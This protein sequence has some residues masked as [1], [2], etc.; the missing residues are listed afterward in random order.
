[1]AGVAAVIQIQSQ[2]LLLALLE[3]G[4]RSEI[5]L[6]EVIVVWYYLLGLLSFCLLLGVV[7]RELHLHLN[8]LI[9]HL[10]FLCNGLRLLAEK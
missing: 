9:W 4:F 7:V 3:L 10:I 2:L 6:N 5:N 8:A 1:L